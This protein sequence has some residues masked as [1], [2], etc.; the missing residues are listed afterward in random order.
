M[1]K[2]FLDKLVGM[3][4][5]D[6]EKAVLAKKHIPYLVPEDCNAIPSLAR[7]NTVVLWQK[8]GKI[9]AA[10]PGDPLELE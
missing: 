2:S 4:V 6:A 8:D 10:D 1:K 5:K 7:G 9:W 3:T